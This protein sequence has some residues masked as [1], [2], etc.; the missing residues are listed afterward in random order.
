MTDKPSPARSTR[1]VRSAGVR[2]RRGPTTSAEAG[3]A[4]RTVKTA[5]PRKGK[6]NAAGEHIDGIWFASKAEAVRYRQLKAML[7]A[8]MIE[9]LECQ[10][11]YPVRLNNHLIC[12][13]RADFRYKVIDE[14]GRTLRVSVEDV[15]GMVTDVY[16]IKR[17]LVVAA[18]HLDLVEIPAKDVTHWE[19]RV[20]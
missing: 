14:L 20:A 12:T 11:S 9:D 5:K 17:K 18:H 10:P 4:K 1:T 16:K 6:Y 2:T 13:Y 3:T 8:G 15:K 7:Q 19:N